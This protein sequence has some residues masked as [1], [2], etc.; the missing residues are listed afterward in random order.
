MIHSLKSV[1]ASVT[2]TRR[3]RSAGDVSMAR[4]RRALRRR[5]APRIPGGRRAGLGQTQVLADS[6]GVLVA[7]PRAF[8]TYSWISW[9]WGVGGWEGQA[10]AAAAR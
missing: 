2:C 4:R 9:G 3:R 6:R 7:L 5:P 1:V 8:K 10:A